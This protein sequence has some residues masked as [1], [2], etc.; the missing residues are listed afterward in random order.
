MER[1][2]AL[3]VFRDELKDYGDLFAFGR[4][5]AKRMLRSPENM[6]VKDILY[7]ANAGCIYNGSG[8]ARVVSCCR[9]PL[10][11]EVRQLNVEAKTLEARDR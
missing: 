1:L 4:A 3:V 5:E 2:K 8:E 7:L 11:V 9:D 10:K 6:N